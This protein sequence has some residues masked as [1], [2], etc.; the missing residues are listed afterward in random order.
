MQT[1]YEFG[2]VEKH[3]LVREVYAW[4]WWWAA[5]TL[6]SRMCYTL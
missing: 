1:C 3:E 5:I 6:Y 4:T 2:E